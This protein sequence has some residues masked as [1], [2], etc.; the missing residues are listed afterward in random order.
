MQK[1]DEI[2]VIAGGKEFVLTGP[3]A[4]ERFCNT[5]LDTYGGR[6]QAGGDLYAPVNGSRKSQSK[7]PTRTKTKSKKQVSESSSETSES[8]SE[9]SEPREPRR[10]SAIEKP[11]PP[12]RGKSSK[13]KG[14]KKKSSKVTRG[15]RRA[16]SESDD[17]PKPGYQK[18]NLKYKVV[19]KDA[20]VM[21]VAKKMQKKGAANFTDV[22]GRKKRPGEE[23]D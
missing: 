4:I 8:E 23:S 17:E 12:K 18:M 21:A 10:R 7:K 13:K 6:A 11:S 20:D 15:R 2:V 1:P 19:D 5:Y 9:S 3:K 14:S 22:P 16:S